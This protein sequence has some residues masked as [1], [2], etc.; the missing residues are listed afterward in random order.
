[1]NETQKLSKPYL[2]DAADL[3]REDTMLIFE[4]AQFFME[5]YKTGSKFD[6]LK[7]VTVALAFFENSTRTKLSFEL[8]AKRLS[9]NTLSF[10]ASS[11]SL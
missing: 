6:D 10:Q 8:A 11:S 9:A 4:K 7:G 2:L 3:T 5:N 1:M